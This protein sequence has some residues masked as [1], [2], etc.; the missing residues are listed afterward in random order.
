MHSWIVSTT[1]SP[2]KAFPRYPVIRQCVTVLLYLFCCSCS[3]QFPLLLFITAGSCGHSRG[4][5]QKGR[6]GSTSVLGKLR[7]YRAFE[8]H[9]M[10]EEQEGRVGP[11]PRLQR[12]FP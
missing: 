10:L 6:T 7:D 12:D 5:E 4:I 8:A 1:K 2:D 3:F 9:K 11:F